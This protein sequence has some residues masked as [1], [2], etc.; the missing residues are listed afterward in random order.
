[1]ALERRRTFPR[2]VSFW[3]DHEEEGSKWLSDAFVGAWL[4]SPSRI[5]GEDVGS[6]VCLVANQS[7]PKEREPQLHYHS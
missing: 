2:D 1:M 7:L 4:T 5:V 3:S 6:N